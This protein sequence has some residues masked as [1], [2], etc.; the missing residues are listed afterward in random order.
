M[1]SRLRTFDW[2]DETGA[3]GPGVG[4]FKF[5]RKI[6]LDANNPAEANRSMPVQD[7]IAQYR[8]AGIL[9]KI[10][11]EYLGQTV[12]QALMSGDSTVRKLLTDGRWGR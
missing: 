5:A 2:G 11:G 10:P 6:G 7:F 12:E 8:N 1:A 3:I 9:Q 4:D